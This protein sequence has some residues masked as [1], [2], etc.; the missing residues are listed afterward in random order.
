MN[1][2][3]KLSFVKSLSTT[4]PYT[5]VNMVPQTQPFSI[6]RGLMGA[7]MV[8]AG[9]SVAL[10]DPDPFARQGLA[11]MLEDS[12]F[13]VCREHDDIGAIVGGDDP[14]HQPAL[15]VVD[16]AVFEA[17]SSAMIARLRSRFP[18]GR[19]VVRARQIDESRFLHCYEAG[20]DAYILKNMTGES[21]IAALTMVL[22]GERV[23]PGSLMGRLMRAHRVDGLNM[24]SKLPDCANL[25]ARER[26]ILGALVDG[27]SNKAIANRLGITEPTVK[28]HLQNLLK[29]L[30]VRNRTQAAIWAIKWEAVARNEAA[31]E[32]EDGESHGSDANRNEAA[33]FAPG[34]LHASDKEPGT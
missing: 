11:K 2:Y 7:I 30:Q 29:K 1:I 18:N 12:A 16:G 27:L 3:N 17:A 19:V 5:R 21:L 10:I 34:R 24:G 9:T 6:T 22:N 13:H 15:I 31:A 32:P 26:Q 23:Y 28:I 4:T 25:S 8:M 14:A 33:D 20:V